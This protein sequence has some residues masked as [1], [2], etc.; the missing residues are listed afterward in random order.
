MASFLHSPSILNAP[1][2]CTQVKQATP[3]KDLKLT[4]SSNDLINKFLSFSRATMLAHAFSTPTKVTEF[5]YKLYN[6]QFGLPHPHTFS[7]L[8][9][10]TNAKDVKSTSTKV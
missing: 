10:P 8:L 2:F 1:T 3:H 5:G 6:Y 9:L 4:T 7:S